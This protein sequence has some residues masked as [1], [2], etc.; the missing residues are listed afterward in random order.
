MKEED[1]DNLNK[2]LEEIVKKYFLKNCSFCGNDEEEHFIGFCV[3][4]LTQITLWSASLNV[5]RL[6]Q[7][8]RGLVR[9]TLSD[10]EVKGNRGAGW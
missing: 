2:D 10:F 6:W 5:G 3:G 4:N 8:I 7:H 1:I 9:M